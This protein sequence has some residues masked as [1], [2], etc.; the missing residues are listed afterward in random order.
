MKNNIN[1]STQNKVGQNSVKE[2]VQ[3]PSLESAPMK[4]WKNGDDELS[5]L[6]RKTPQE[7]LK[8][9]VGCKDHEICLA[10]LG[11]S[12]Q[13]LSK[14]NSNESS[15]LNI[16]VQSLHDFKPKDAME[17]RLVSQ[18]T[19]SFHYA[20]NLLSRSAGA[21]MLGH[22]ESFGN[23]ALKLMRAHNE[24]VD[25]LARYRRG[26]QQH[27]VVQHVADKMAVINNF[28]SQEGGGINKNE[29]DT[30]CQQN[31]AQEPELT[32]ID[33]ADSPQW[34]TGDVA[35]TEALAQ[36]LLKPDVSR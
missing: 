33:H 20:M 21:D 23:L 32:N 22:L 28:G 16:L 9:V 14:F 24:A 29:G 15:A 25:A 19:V 7:S 5:L 1:K 13:P 11:A 27:I 6:C 3:P 34:L 31:A 12:W 4:Y 30:P 10:I 8:E 17:A 18:A 26:G 35:F 2:S 36:A